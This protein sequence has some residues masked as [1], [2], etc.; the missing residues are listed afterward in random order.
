MVNIRDEHFSDEYAKK[1]VIEQLT[2]MFPEVSAEIKKL[3]DIAIGDTSFN[4]NTNAEVFGHPEV[5]LR[6]YFDTKMK[7]IES[8]LTY[9][10]GDAQERILKDRYSV[11]VNQYNKVFNPEKFIV[12]TLGYIMGSITQLERVMRSRDE[13]T[14]SIYQSELEEAVLGFNDYLKKAHFDFKNDLIE[15]IRGINV[16]LRKI[17]MPLIEC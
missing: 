5:T 10:K 13:E 1:A 15:Q 17:P 12:H 14:A 6:G 8:A 7:N 9:F 3:E 4:P 2:L 11:L 16:E